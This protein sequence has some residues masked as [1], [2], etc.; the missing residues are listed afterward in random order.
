M[1][2]PFQPAYNVPNAAV[3]GG[4]ARD[5]RTHER[6]T[7]HGQ[8]AR[9]KGVQGSRAAS[10]RLR[11]L[12]LLARAG[13]GSLTSRRG[14]SV[15]SRYDARQGLVLRTQRPTGGLVRSP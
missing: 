14:Q 15:P 5:E 1:C 13:A 12:E 8:P 3:L 4:P 7:A 6:A 2:H 11:L 9:L 10:E